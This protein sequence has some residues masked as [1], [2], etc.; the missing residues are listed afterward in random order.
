MHIQSL[1]FISASSY[2]FK[3]SLSA[4]CNWTYI[5][6][7]SKIKVRT[8]KSYIFTNR[9]L[10]ELIFSHRVLTFVF[11]VCILLYCIQYS[12]NNSKLFIGP[13]FLTRQ[14]NFLFHLVLITHQ[15][16]FWTSKFIL[17]RNSKH[18]PNITPLDKT[19]A[20]WSISSIPLKREYYDPS[21]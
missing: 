1:A 11:R 19:F 16:F 5:A 17:F 20:E 18:H 4:N 10:L 21:P 6:V 13:L 9:T 7:W 12:G 3:K 8:I 2:T 14:A 15:A